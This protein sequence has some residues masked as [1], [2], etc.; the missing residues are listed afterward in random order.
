MCLAQTGAGNKQPWNDSCWYGAV[1]AANAQPSS[2]DQA[3]DQGQVEEA[4][5]ISAVAAANAAPSSLDDTAD[6]VHKEDALCNNVIKVFL[7]LAG[8]KV[9]MVI[10]P[11]RL[12]SNQLEPLWTGVQMSGP[13]GCFAELCKSPTKR[14]LSPEAVHSERSAI[15]KRRHLCLPATY[16]NVAVTAPRLPCSRKSWHSSAH[17]TRH[18]T[19]ALL[20]AATP[21]K[22]CLAL[23]T[24]YQGL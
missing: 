23:Q 7:Q 17:G 10:I 3:P 11:A 12:P 14:P 24:C 5:H 2:P 22:H 13:N 6:N 8:D 4:N 9:R 19:S 21:S 18:G 20:Q 15:P 16:R 1:A